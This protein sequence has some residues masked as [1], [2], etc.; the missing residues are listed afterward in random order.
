MELGGIQQDV[1][2]PCRLP[3]VDD[4]EGEAHEAE[5]SQESSQMGICE[6]L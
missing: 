3:Q 1:K 4:D 2:S 6:A 5:A